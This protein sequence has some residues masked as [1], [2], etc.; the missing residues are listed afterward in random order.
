ML[1]L[2][3][4]MVYDIKK[5]TKMEKR[6]NY[7]SGLEY[8]GRFIIAGQL[9]SEQELC[10]IYGITGR[11]P[12]SQA[13]RMIKKENGVWVEPTD[14]QLIISGKPE[15]LIYPAIM[16]S[17][18]GIVVSNGKHTTD[19]AG[20]LDSGRRPVLVLARALQDW[21]YEPDEP[22]FTPRISLAYC[23]GFSVGMSIIR[24]GEFGSVIRNFFELPLLPG[25]GWLLMTYMGINV[26]PLPS[27]FGEPVSLEM[28]GST[29]EEVA[30]GVYE[31]LAPAAG[32]PDLR[33]A[34]A[35]VRAT[36]PDGEILEI[37]IINRNEG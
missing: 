36:L 1:S 10:L 5:E 21:K 9:K 37:K 23:G 32:K 24:R 15:L 11:S 12:S 20:S 27:F 4:E 2:T 3:P 16:Y 29:A 6:A 34:V 33:V 25:K 17:P 7:L 26:D 14:P 8:P 13:R 30:Q 28:V 22:V 35:G 18:S 31:S 19:I